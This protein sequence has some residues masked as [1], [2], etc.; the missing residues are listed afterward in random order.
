MEEDVMEL[1]ELMELEDIMDEEEEELILEDLLMRASFNFFTFAS[2]ARREM[3]CTFT[4]FTLEDLPITR[5][6]RRQVAFARPV[7]DLHAS[8]RMC[9]RELRRT[10]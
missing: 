8:L 1:T 10:S 9:A 2:K 5:W 3:R 6:R 4:D 7:S